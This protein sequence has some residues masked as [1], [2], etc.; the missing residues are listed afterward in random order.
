[1]KI[2]PD[3]NESQLIDIAAVIRES[4]IDGV[5]VS[6]TTT[7][8]PANLKDRK[9]FGCVTLTILKRPCLANKTQMG[10]LSGAPIKPYSLKALRTL[11]SHL[12]ASIPLIGC[13]GI[14]SGADALE[15]ARAGASL[16]QVYTSF[17]YDGAGAC[18][19]IKDQ[20]VEEL[21]KEGTTWSEVVESAVNQLSFKGETPRNAERSSE[22]PIGQLILEAQELKGLL[23]K[24]D[25]KIGSDTA[26]LS[27]TN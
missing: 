13:G 15:Y 5:I 19:R 18:R 27:T 26:V 12:P 7:Q 8:R 4:N 11:R 14:S 23:D 20:L 24:L 1:L 22:G 2:A 17:G 16:V 10:G 25:E 6:N 3:L 9:F 21:A